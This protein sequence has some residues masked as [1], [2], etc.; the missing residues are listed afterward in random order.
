VRKG[1]S[2]NKGEV[3]Y[4]EHGE[5]GL[6]CCLTQ[7][8]GKVKQ[9]CDQHHISVES[10]CSPAH[11]IIFTALIAEAENNPDHQVEFKLF[12]AKLGHLLTEVGGELALDEI[13]SLTNIANVEQYIRQ[14]VEYGKRRKALK[15]SHR[16]AQSDGDP[17]LL[18]QA[19]NDLQDIHGLNGD[20]PRY[21]EIDPDNLVD[22]DEEPIPKF[23]LDALPLTLRAPVEELMRH[24]GVPAL[25]PAICALVA[26]SVALG[27]GVFAL[28]DVRRTYGN[29]Y[30]IIGA[31]S[32]SGK[33]PPFEELT[34]PLMEMQNELDDQFKE[35]IKPRLQA[36]LK[37]LTAEIT[38]LV[39]PKTKRSGKSSFGKED[40]EQAEEEDRRA[41]LAKL[42][43]EQAKLEE[44][45]Q[46]TG[47]IW[48]E[49]FT[50]EAL[51]V[52]LANNN[53]QLAVL[54][55]DGGI[56]I[57]NLLGRYTE[58][59]VKDD[60]FLCKAKTVSPVPVD[61]IGRDSILLKRPCLTMLVLTQPDLL[62]RL[63]SNERILLGGFM[64][65]CLFADSQMEIQDRTEASFEMPDQK[66]MADW[67]QYIR[68]VAKK[69]RFSQNKE[70]YQIWVQPAVY[71]RSQD[72]YNHWA[73]KARGTLSD[74]ASFAI[75]NC[76]RAWEIAINL[77]IG[78]HGIN[79]ASYLDLETFENA[80][81]IADFFA[82]RQ[83]EVLS[84]PR[85]EAQEK[86]VSRLE[87]V[88]A[89]HGN[90]PITMRTLVRT[91]GMKK[92]DVLSSV[93]SRTDLF[94][95]TTVDPPHGGSKSTVVFPRSNPPPGWRSR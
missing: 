76:E 80:I 2:G 81:R 24:Y 54:T 22:D 29:L 63:V 13:W 93:K 86:R 64:A 55:D 58:G 59:E 50:S 88:F 46:F 35:E 9:L 44:E 33:T 39:K 1:L 21:E 47:R 6:L 41:R 53:E 10:F 48:T 95:F 30:A 43:G 3:P 87:E 68:S 17:A 27:R 25:L 45:L 75:R 79:C 38:E 62:H 42:I 36:D 15:V 77:H 49:D 5:K 72:Y 67:N 70:P 91:H 83:L 32:G 61:R 37:I 82:D 51:G 26:N 11:R 60:T 78:I 20:T 84:R 66:V 19:I 16:I 12:C 4:S 14:V 74:V 31:K 40:E 34:A 18:G 23:P 94:C 52:L 90:Q 56:V 7:E 71:K 73:A 57:H 69:F 92:E 28:S 8:P 65:R 89:K 85:I